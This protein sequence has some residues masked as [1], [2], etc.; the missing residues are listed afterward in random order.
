M[1]GPQIQFIGNLTRDP[2]QRFPRN[3]DNPYARMSVAVNTYRGPEQ[4]ADTQYFTVDVWGRPGENAMNR[5]QKGTQVFVQGRY[6]L[7]KY[8][9]QDG[10]EGMAQEVNASSFRVLQRTRSTDADE[11]R[12]SG[13]APA[14]DASPSEPEPETQEDFGEYG[15]YPEY[16]D[17]DDQDGQGAGEYD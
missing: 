3:S 11:T 14:S 4:E 12:P 1:N 7:R 5:C 9:R 6:S 15:D 8:N 16:D 2:E 10:A 17:T 13:E